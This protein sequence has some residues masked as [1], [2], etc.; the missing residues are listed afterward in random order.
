M[1]FL[2]FQMVIY[3]SVFQYFPSLSFCPMYS[4]SNE[5]NP[6]RPDIVNRKGVCCPHSLLSGCWC[7]HPCRP[8]LNCQLIYL[9]QLLQSNQFSCNLAL[10][11][12]HGFISCIHSSAADK[13]VKWCMC[14]N[15]Q[16]TKCQIFLLSLAHVEHSLETIPPRVRSTTGVLLLPTPPSIFL[17]NCLLRV[18]VL[19]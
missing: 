11:D 7:T 5:K 18:A 6:V 13:L 8:T 16:D 10:L 3:F 12:W 2:W 14:I 9:I 19:N 15:P 1:N 4:Y 17:P